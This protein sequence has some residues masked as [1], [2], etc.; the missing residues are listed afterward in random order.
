MVG[1]NQSFNFRE[2]SDFSGIPQKRPKSPRKS[3]EMAGKMAKTASFS[4]TTR[5]DFQ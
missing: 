3:M 2:P 4:H 1:D 5:D